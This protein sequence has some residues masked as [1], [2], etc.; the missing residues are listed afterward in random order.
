MFLRFHEVV[1]LVYSITGT[2]D[3][4]Q[5]TLSVV[6]PNTLNVTVRYIE[7]TIARGVFLVLHFIGDSPTNFE[8]SVY[9][10]FDS[11][12]PSVMING[13]SSGEYRVLAYDLENESLPLGYNLP[14]T[15][16]RIYIGGRGM[17]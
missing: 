5:T 12:I 9:K 10:I 15:T 3:I 17:Y 11:T 4:Q 8:N 16:D 7:N 13:I 6:Q 14:A 2:H 1:N